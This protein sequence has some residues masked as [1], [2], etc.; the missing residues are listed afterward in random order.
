VTAAGT[1]TNLR[2]GIAA[3]LDAAGVVSW[4]A[5]GVV[6]ATRPPVFLSTYPD[7]PDIACALSTYGAGGDEGTLSGSLVMLQ[8]RCRSQPDVV[9]GC[10]DLDDAIAGQ[11]LGHFPLVLS[12]GLRVT[13]ILR[14]SGTPLGRDTAGRMERTTNY[15]IRIH[16]P[17]AYRG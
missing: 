8:V 14:R 12:T 11:L 6:D 1:Q 17:G 7:Q 16:E 10:D 2:V 3:M 15:E 4:T 13:R 5:S 9:T